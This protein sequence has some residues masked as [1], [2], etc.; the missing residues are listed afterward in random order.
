MRIMAKNLKLPNGYGSVTKMSNANRRR[1]PYVVRITTGY[2]IDNNTGKSTQKYGIIGYVKTR[3]EGRQMLA[4][5]HEQPFDLENSNITFREVYELWSEEKYENATR[6]TINGYRAAYNTC[7][8]IFEKRFRDLNMNDLQGIIDNCNKNYPTLRKIKILFNQLF[9]YAV[10]HDICSKDYSRYI[11]IAK[12]SNKNPDK[13]DR[14]PFTK[15]QIDILWTLKNDKYYQLILILI[16]TGLRIEEFLSLKKKD[17]NIKEHYLNVIKTKTESG[18]RKVPISDYIYPFVLNWYKS[19]KCD[20]LLHTENQEPF[21]YRNYYDSYFLP[22]M[23]RLGFDQTP[24]CCRHTFISLLAEAKISPTYTKLIVGHKGAMS[25]TE[26]VY[27][28]IDMSHLLEAVNSIYYPK[29]N[30]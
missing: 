29:I 14:K 17:V 5:Y 3:E 28:H 19:S 27:T 8:I 26:K 2:S 16:Y 4:K 7:T 1:K 6:S 23:E 9:A 24:H 10:K 20:Y 15:K 30:Q 11:D 18:I 13:Y 12:Y 22:L 25:L 21:K